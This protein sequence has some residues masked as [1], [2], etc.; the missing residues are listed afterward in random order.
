VELSKR[1]TYLAVVGLMLVMFLVSM[2]QTVV[3]TAMPR[4]NIVKGAL[5]ALRS[6][7]QTDDDGE[8]GRASEEEIAR[9]LDNSFPARWRTASI[10]HPA[11]RLARG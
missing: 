2:D 10:F 11:E 7:R 8:R 1:E 5:V 6:G 3:G 9:I 4:R